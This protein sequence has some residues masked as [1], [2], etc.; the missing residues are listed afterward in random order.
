MPDKSLQGSIFHATSVKSP[1]GRI[2]SFE[3]PTDNSWTAF[4]IIPDVRWLIFSPKGRHLAFTSG[5]RNSFVRDLVTGNTSDLGGD[6][7]GH[8]A[9]S[10]DGSYL[11]LSRLEDLCVWKCEAGG[12]D[13]VELTE[14]TFSTGWEVAFSPDG[15]YLACRSRN[16]NIHIWNVADR[17]SRVLSGGIG[18]DLAC[19]ITFSPDN[20]HIVL[21]TRWRDHIWDI[22]AQPMTCVLE[23]RSGWADPGVVF[24]PDGHLVASANDRYVH[25]W[26]VSTWTK[27]FTFKHPDYVGT[28]AFSPQGHQLASCS[29]NRTITIWDLMTD[30]K[31]VV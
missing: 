27:D 26:K 10:P 1:R 8:M 21:S 9:L 29:Y 15:R 12:T 5:S 18:P 6:S 11:A 4:S 17:T 19:S 20:R 31:S 7:V 30:R 25:L 16:G 28:V 23:Q 14:D 2:H 24:S 22:A 13:R 3:S